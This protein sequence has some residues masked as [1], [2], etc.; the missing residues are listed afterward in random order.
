MSIACF[1][2]QFFYI[3]WDKNAPRG[4]R[5]YGFKC[6]EIPSSAVMRVTG[7]SCQLGKKKEVEQEKGMTDTHKVKNK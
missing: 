5:A 6:S 4:C 7:M 1:E 2:C 3:T